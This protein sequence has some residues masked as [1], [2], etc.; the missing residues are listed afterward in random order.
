MLNHLKR[1]IV[2]TAYDAGEGH[3]PS[4]FSVLDIIWV[5]YNRILRPGPLYSK[6]DRFILSKGH[7]CLA[8]YTVLVE[9]GTLPAAGLKHF[10]A[11][12]G[13]L[14]GHPDWGIPGVEAASGSLG[15]GLAIGVGMAMGLQ[16]LGINRRIF[17]LM[18]DEECHE[19]S[20]WEAALLAAALQLTSV[21]V[22]VDDNQSSARSVGVGDLAAKFGAFDWQAIHVDGHDHETLVRALAHSHPR[23]PTAVI[24][25]TVKGNGCKRMEGNPAWHHRVPTETELAEILEELA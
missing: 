15:H 21:T 14:G 3:I 6:R 22:I 17:V 9:G 18:G 5:L 7:G 1:L 4:A 23:R 10:T 16:M 20:V 8:L 2:Q 13:L 24:A 12:D 19:G 25:H 11:Y